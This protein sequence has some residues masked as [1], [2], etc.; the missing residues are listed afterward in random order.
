MLTSP[1]TTRTRITGMP[2]QMDT[3][4][5]TRTRSDLRIM[6]SSGKTDMV[7]LVLHGGRSRSDKPARK[8]HLAYQRMVPIAHGLRRAA[9]PSTGVWLLRN[10]LRGWNEPAQDAVADGRWAV[11]EARQRHPRARIVLVGHSLGGRVALRLAGEDAVVAVC[12]L[13]PWIEPDEP[14]EQL[15]GKAVLI[16]HGTEDRTTSPTAS[17]QYAR[18]AGV[19]QIEISRSGH[20]MLRRWREW[21]SVTRRFV[22]SVTREGQR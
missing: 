3:S 16:A 19:Q 20:A 8:R 2:C 17:A 18:S 9:P 14:V 4:S 6:P 15:A 11:T 21:H 7:V 10:R 5:D 13:A 12:A 22:L 1:W